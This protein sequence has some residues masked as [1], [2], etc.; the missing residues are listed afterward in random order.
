MEARA[1]GVEP[2]G[3]DV[4]ALF[5]QMD[6]PGRARVAEEAFGRLIDLLHA[7][8]ERARDRCG[9]FLFQR[10]GHR[11]HL[12]R[13]AGAT[14]LP[15]ANRRAGAAPSR[16]PR[17]RAVPM[18]R[19]ACRGRHQR[20]DVRVERL[21][22]IVERERDAAAVERRVEI[23]VRAQ[24]ERDVERRPPRR[25]DA[26]ERCRAEHP[27]E[28]VAGPQHP[29]APRS[30]E[31]ARADR[32]CRSTGRPSHHRARPEISRSLRRDRHRHRIVVP[33]VARVERVEVRQ[34]RLLV[35]DRQ[36]RER[37][38]APSASAVRRSAPSARPAAIIRPAISA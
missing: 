15:S 34:Q 6:R 5:V 31:T 12:A 7:A 3:L 4:H 13:M 1:R 35:D 25:G 37:D 20:I 11:N 33:D 9:V 21:Q 8:A 23:A 38:A 26:R 36:I 14:G 32:K 24:E 10:L 22:Q 19:C 27:R 29:F 17:A 2:F 18:R 30:R 28:D 16:E